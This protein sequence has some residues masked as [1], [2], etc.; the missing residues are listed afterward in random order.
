MASLQANQVEGEDRWVLIFEHTEVTCE[1][2]QFKYIID[3]SFAN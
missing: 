3:S 2:I 1:L